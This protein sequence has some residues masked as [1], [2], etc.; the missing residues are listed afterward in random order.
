M[1]NE[2]WRTLMSNLH[3]PIR[4]ALHCANNKTPWK[5]RELPRLSGGA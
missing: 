5:V 1:D 4:F 3:S 2:G